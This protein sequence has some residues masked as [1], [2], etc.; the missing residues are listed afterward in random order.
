MA[1]ALCGPSSALQ[2][3]QK[4]TQQDRTL[5]QDRIVSRPGASSGFRTPSQNAG[6]LDPEFEAFQAGVQAPATL[7][8]SAF[9]QQSIPQRNH[10][11][12]IQQAS[13][14]A[15]DWA[16]D[17]QRLNL[18]TPSPVSTGKARASP[19]APAVSHASSTQPMMAPVSVS[20]FAPMNM[21]EPSY[22]EMAP[23]MY[24]SGIGMDYRSMQQPQMEQHHMA[25]APQ[26]A[27]DAEAFERAFEAASVEM[28]TNEQMVNGMTRHV[29][30]ADWGMRD[31]YT[32]LSETPISPESTVQQEQAQQ[33][34]QQNSSQ[35]N[36]DALA[37]TAGQL[38][39][40]VSHETS[41]KF[42]QSSFLTLMRRLRDHEVVVEGENFIE[43]SEPFTMYGITRL[44]GQSST[45]TIANTTGMA[46][47]AVEE[48][49]SLFNNHSPPV[50]PDSSGDDVGEF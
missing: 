10:T 7:P 31:G 23:S 41:E 6:V 2:N 30:K 44:T 29:E 47:E 4:H 39:A 34:Q 14:P 25:Q 20:G 5:Q 18:S 3:F 8:V 26:M 16:L 43:V 11:P 35:P 12:I 36:P 50:G 22:G 24:G 38:L 46:T 40:T 19:L 33:K 9:F 21:Y 49:E 48:P 37:Q 27:F 17:F 28:Q 32:R 15:P 42:A 45:N 1:D 13:S